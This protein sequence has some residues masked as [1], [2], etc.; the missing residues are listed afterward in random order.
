MV[1]RETVHKAGNELGDLVVLLLDAVSNKEQITAFAT[2][3]F[4]AVSALAGVGIPVAQ[5]PAIVTHL[6][7]AILNRI[8][9]AALILP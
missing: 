8:N 9:E 7:E 1:T 6:V 5:R 4:E 3:G 2:E